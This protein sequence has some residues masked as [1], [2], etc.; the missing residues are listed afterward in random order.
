MVRCN[1]YFINKLMK[2]VD[3]RSHQI[4]TIDSLGG[5]HISVCQLV[6]YLNFNTI[7]IAP[8]FGGA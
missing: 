2:V 6:R 1:S 8:N 5:S 4:F 7:I 3:L